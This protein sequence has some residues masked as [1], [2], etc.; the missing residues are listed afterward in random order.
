MQSEDLPDA[1][2]IPLIVRKI[3]KSRDPKSARKSSP[4]VHGAPDIRVMECNSR[5]RVN[6]RRG[7]KKCHLTATLAPSKTAPTSLDAAYKCDIYRRRYFK[8][9]NEAQQYKGHERAMIAQKKYKGHRALFAEK[10]CP[11]VPGPR[12]RNQLSAYRHPNASKWPEEGKKQL[13][14]IE[15]RKKNDLVSFKI[16]LRCKKAAPVAVVPHREKEIEEEQVPRGQ[17]RSQQSF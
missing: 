11:R 1:P 14:G 15:K 13:K 2:P 9:S 3:S 4:K 7:N 16:T 5:E 12:V 6:N 10:N 8:Y 17:H